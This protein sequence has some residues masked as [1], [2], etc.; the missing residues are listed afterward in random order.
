MTEPVGLSMFDTARCWIA[1]SAPG[2]DNNNWLSR[3]DTRITAGWL[4]DGT[5]GFMWTADRRTNRPFP[6]VKAV[7]LDADS[8]SV[9][10]QPDIWNNN[11]AF[12]YP[13]A[14]PN[15]N[16]DVGVTMMYG[17]GQKFPG[18]LIGTWDDESS[19]WRLHVARN[20]TNGPLDAK[21]GDY[22]TV[23]PH[24]PDGDTWA[25]VGYT[26]QG[27]NKQDSVQPQYVHFGP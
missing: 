8:M 26:L 13:A 23:R 21:G 19:R 25:A 9:V 7:R 6:Y 2:P 22:T 27:G 17:G 3:C 16:G 11:F 14:A 24:W 20:G 15:R 18:M 5:L 1:S 4:A 12:A 10:D